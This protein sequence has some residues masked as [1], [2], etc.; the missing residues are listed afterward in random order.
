MG[1]RYTIHNI[2]AKRWNILLDRFRRDLCE[3]RILSILL[4]LCVVL[5]LMPAASAEDAADTTDSAA[6]YSIQNIALTP[7]ADTAK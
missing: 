3:K 5:T 1:F 7:A 4:T 2:P 6:V